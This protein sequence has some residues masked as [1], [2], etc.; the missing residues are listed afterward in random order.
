MKAFTLLAAFLFATTAQV[1]TQA[2]GV[3][4]CGPDGRAYSD[5]PCAQGRM[6]AVADT[7]SA[8]QVQGA[9][10]VVARDRA[11]AR[12]MVQERRDN[13]REAL[14]RSGITGFK[15]AAVQSE[16]AEKKPKRAPKKTAHRG[17]EAAD[18]SPAIVPVSRRVR[19]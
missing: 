6:V 13:E 17:S 8:T 1:H 19:G 15:S 14:S 7:R 16:K 3:W 4:R 2:Q 9:Q 12:Q 18:I 11:L 10:D 5:S